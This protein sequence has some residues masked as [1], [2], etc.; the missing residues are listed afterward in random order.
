MPSWFEISSWVDVVDVGLVATF[1]WLA[2][3]YIRRTRDRAALTGLSLLSVV[4]FVSRALELR[5]TALLLQAFFA[6]VVLVL[7]VVFQEDLRRMFEQLGTWRRSRTRAVP[8]SASLD[9]L[10]RTVVR[11]AATRTGALILLPGRD[12]LD[13]HIEGGILLRGEVSEPLLLSLFDASSPG[14]DGA[15]ILRGSI[16][17]RFAVHLPLSA[18]REALGPGG[19]RHAAALGLAEHCDAI[20]IAVSEERGTV[21]VARQGSIRTL[22]R[23]ED[24]AAEL[25]S[26]YH[27]ER[28]PRA[29]WR[30]PRIAVDAAIAVAAA[31]VLWTVFIPGS[32]LGE[33]TV[34]APVEVTNLPANLRLESVD[35]ATVEVTL[36]GLQRDLFLEDPASVSVRI[37]AYLSRLGRRSFAVTAQDVR[38]PSELSVVVVTPEKVRLSM[39]TI[40]DPPPASAVP[41]VP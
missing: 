12:P 36:R 8:K 25:H 17:E 32:D 9:L 35:P 37:D 13:R 34:S 23:P 6:V 11:L 7:I 1:C 31:L 26:V 33:I 18:N 15:V 24:L 22:A 2:I 14:H 20:C 30:D 21:S 16:V 39:Q 27:D 29:G 10:V 3:R 41:S 38:K 28:Q 40:P 5:L 19:T 4:Y